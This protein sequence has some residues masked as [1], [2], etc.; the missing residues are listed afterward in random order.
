[1]SSSAIE[2]SLAM[3]IDRTANRF[4][5]LLLGILALDVFSSRE[6][7]AQQ[8]DRLAY[9]EDNNPWYPHA[10]F[11][12][13]TTPQWVGEEGVEA[14][15]VLAI[16]DMRDSAKYEAYLRPILQRLKQIDGRAPVSIMTCK[17]Q[18]EDPQLQSWLD[19][20]LSLEVHTVDHPCPLLKEGDFAAAKSTYER[21]VDLL[22]TIP[23]NK[24]V[25]F[26]MPCCDSLN[27]VSPRFYSEIFD[28]ITPQGKFLSISSSV[29]NVFT[30]EDKS[31]P[32]ELLFDGDGRE[33]FRK[34]I[35]HQNN[36][37]PKYRFNNFIENY[38][39]PYVINRSCWEFPC[40][41][42]S[43]WEAQALHKPNNPITVADMRAAL[44]ITAHKQGVFCLVFHPHGWIQNNQVVELIDHAVQK[45]GRKIKFLTFAE[46]QSRLNKHL[47]HDQPLRDAKGQD[48]G[49]R[50]V[51]VNQDG[52]QDVVI[53]N[54][55]KQETRIWQ[56][57]SRTFASTPFAPRILV[58][59]QKQ[60]TQSAVGSYFVSM[61]NSGE[62]KFA[63]IRPHSGPASGGV[64]PLFEAKRDN[65]PLIFG[66]STINRSRS[67]RMPSMTKSPPRVAR[68]TCAPS[69]ARARIPMIGMQIRSARTIRWRRLSR[70]KTVA[71]AGRAGSVS[72]ALMTAPVA[73][74][75]R[76]PA[77]GRVL[78]L[79]ACGPSPVLNYARKYRFRPS[80]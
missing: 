2:G 68:N 67:S 58:T 57:N 38:P 18:P 31:I 26:R 6:L 43:D 12:K 39:Y 22:G 34:Y 17:V 13:L 69:T 25:T 20:G 80:P 23:R 7:P 51:D 5:L 40:M 76:S 27:T 70:A 3:T 62:L 41:V 59:D 35:P 64:P 37:P 79:P 14:V 30:P 52:F 65:V 66:R 10:T 72:A 33:R 56:P 60:E 29:F 54:E 19:E 4:S 61:P 48:N 8:G 77:S 50:L 21:C 73:A 63:S 15:V 71:V 9:L 28:R 53:G 47:L 32:R 24:P 75:G 55:Q 46:A 78:T 49:V 36:S 74:A 1:M 44:D 42:P 11:P 16:D 45:H